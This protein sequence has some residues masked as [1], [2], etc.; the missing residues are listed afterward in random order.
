MQ[1]K[2]AK[3]MNDFITIFG[4]IVIMQNIYFFIHMLLGNFKADSLEI[5]NLQQI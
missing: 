1:Q 5:G 3:R 4:F 2:Q